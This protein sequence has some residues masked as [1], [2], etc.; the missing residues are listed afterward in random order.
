[1]KIPEY[2]VAVEQK[3]VPEML[4]MLLADVL[5]CEIVDTERARDRPSL[6]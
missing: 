4:Y 3:G 6:V 1:M 2:T 5:N